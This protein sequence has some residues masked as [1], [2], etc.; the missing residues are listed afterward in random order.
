MLKFKHLIYILVLISVTACKTSPAEDGE[1]TSLLVPTPNSQD[2]T[3]ETAETETET[4]PQPLVVSSASTESESSGSVLSYNVQPGEFNLYPR[5]TSGWDET[6]WSIMTPSEDSRLIYV[7]SSAGDDETAEFYALRDV[8][9]VANPGLIKPF[10]TIAAANLS[11]R[12]GFPDWIILRQGDVWELNELVRLKAGRSVTERSVIT[13]YG[14]NG[15]RPIIKVNANEAFRIWS[16]RYYVAVSGIEFYAHKRDP[17]SA[18][19]SGWGE[20]SES[21]AIRVY[22]PQETTMGTILL[23]GNDFNYFSKGISINGGGDVLDVVIRRNTFRNSYSE[24]AH[25]QGI[26]AEHTSAILEENLFDHNGWY[27]QQIGTGN[28]KP[29]GQANMFNHNTYFAKSFNTKFLRNIFLRSS[30]IQN[31]WTASSDSNSNVDSI[32]SHDLLMEDNV[33]VGGEIGISAGGNTD[34]DTGPRW[35]NI[36][37]INN[38]MLAIGRDQPTNRTLGWNIEASDW[39]GGLICGNYV[40]HT[41]NPVVTNLLGIKLKGHSSDVTI[42]E[43]TIHGLISGPSSKIGGISID[44]APKSNIT[45]SGNSIQLTESNMRVIVADHLESVSFDG[46]KYYSGL[47]GAEWFHSNGVSYDID[48]WR[49]LSGDVNST[50]G[51]DAYLEPRRTFETYLLSIGLS[52]SIDDFTQQAVNQSKTNWRSDL[53]AQ[54]V[55]NYIREGYGNTKCSN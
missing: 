5:E 54:S 20:T 26:Y 53:S 49:S 33:Y 8:G 46:N 27:K 24:T 2:I 6:G 23:E 4:E 40:L 36:T 51:E 3:I 55:L 14:Q 42:A 30:S 48:A 34:Y 39:E 32:R 29:E 21:T 31:K 7:S 22:S 15:S 50:V 12:E 47:D 38:V 18:E 19:F 43:N 41:D 45:I 1:P 25:S 35:K 52:E 9:N 44:G 28:D 37:I 11:A 13:S 17:A 10:K 16:N